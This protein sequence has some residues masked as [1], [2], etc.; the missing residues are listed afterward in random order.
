MARK[1][2]SSKTKAQQLQALRIVTFT[3]VW[4]RRDIFEICIKGIERLMNYAPD[5]FHITP[6]FIVSESWAA[7]LLFEKGFEFI[8]WQ[9]QPLGA[10]K[11]A[12]LKYLLENYKFD[13]LL[14]IG[15]DDIIANNYL[16]FVEDHLRAG[17]HQIWPSNCWFLDTITAKVHYYE[18]QKIIGL[19]RFISR[20]ALKIANGRLFLWNETANR[21]MDTYSWNQLKHCEI[22]GQQLPSNTNVY[23]LDIKSKVNVNA[24]YKFPE[25]KYNVEKILSHFPDEVSHIERLLKQ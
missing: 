24:A 18:A 9:N 12:G 7:K 4:Q 21:G 1:Q 19:G 25:S 5:R 14:E 11:N 2:T 20:A 8:F 13:Y 16:D 6:F 17:I 15:S 10:K 22:F 3:P 23:T